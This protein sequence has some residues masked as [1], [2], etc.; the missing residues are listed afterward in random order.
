MDYSIGSIVNWSLELNRTNYWKQYLSVLFSWPK[1]TAKSLGKCN[2]STRSSKHQERLT[3]H[4]VGFCSLSKRLEFTPARPRAFSWVRSL[5]NAV[6]T[7]C[8]RHICLAQILFYAQGF[9]LISELRF[10]KYSKISSLVILDNF[11][12]NLFL[13]LR[14]YSTESNCFSLV[15]ILL[16]FS[17]WTNL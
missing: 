3:N 4:H 5:W 8:E 9:I 16:K 15:F 13:W 7:I 14:I 12:L 11:S 17:R 1:S 6:M 10:L 2:A